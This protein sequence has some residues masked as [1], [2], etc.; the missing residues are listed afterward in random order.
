M[1]LNA[2]INQLNE[3]FNLLAGSYSVTVYSTTAGFQCNE[4][5]DLTIADATPT[6]FTVNDNFVTAF[7]TPISDNFLSNDGGLDIEVSSVGSV[8]NGTLM[9]QPDGSFTFTPD[10]GFAGFTGFS[11][12][13][14]DACGQTLN[15]NVTI[16]VRPP[17]CNYTVELEVFNAVCELPNGMINA[18]VRPAGDNCYEWSNEATT[19]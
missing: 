15:G 14:I 12:T 6:I 4:N 19:T 17:T 8:P 11:Y 18:D 10:F 16:N 13:I 7:N 5:I 3:S 1:N 9:H 2:G